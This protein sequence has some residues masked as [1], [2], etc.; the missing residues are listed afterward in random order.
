LK[1]ATLIAAGA[2]ATAGLLAGGY[3]AAATVSGPNPHAGAHPP[4]NAVMLRPDTHRAILAWVPGRMPSGFG[5]IAGRMDAVQHVAVV[6]SGTT[7]LSSSRAADGRPVDRA[8]KGLAI[9][10]ETAA[11]QV[12]SYRAFLPAAARP[13]LG[14]L[15][16]G[17]AVLGSTSAKIRH[18]G[19]GATLTFGHRTLQV[20]G[21][22]SDDLMGAN[23]VLVSDA[24]GRKLGITQPRYALLDPT[25]DALARHIV[26]GLRASISGPMRI[27]LP[28]ETPYLRQG[29]AVLPPVILKQL[30]G[31][32]AARP[33]AGGTLRV[34]PTWRRR[35]VESR[36]VPILGR[37]TCNRSI[38]PQLVGALTEIQRE[39]LAHLV[40]PADYGGCYSPRFVNHNPSVGISHHSWGV[41]IDINVSQN[42]FG[43][44]PSQDPRIVRAFADWGFTWGG[45]WLVPDGM[46]FE[47]LN[48][49]HGAT[50]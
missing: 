10:L 34:D 11:V 33:D 6:R 37:V 12:P 38:F 4:A 45:N 42:P 13:L 19:A 32:F 23:E 27:R 31:E 15:A 43:H 17:E 24:T 7:W 30:F 20:A 35:Y 44:S 21:V 14:A 26:A 22:L 1:R 36:D 41:A 8:P 40:D 49:P 16:S 48:P 46:H 3:L 2:A 25:A 18:L 9:P 28:G 5:A 50:R 47:Y 39:G 29:D